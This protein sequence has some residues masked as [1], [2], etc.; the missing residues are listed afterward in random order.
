MIVMN[1]VPFRAVTHI[2]IA[3]STS[4]QSSQSLMY[5]NP[6]PIDIV[7]HDLVYSKITKH[8]QSTFCRPIKYHKHILNG[9]S[10]IIKH[11]KVTAIMGASGAGKTTLLNILAQRVKPTRDFYLSGQVL[12]NMQPYA[13][14][15]FGDFAS[16][17][18]QAD[19]LMETLTVRELLQFAA[20]LKING[21]V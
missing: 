3:S 20:A 17:I 9:V 11:G 14:E 21:T 12:A 6:S 7:F 15:N 13:Y 10:G 16:Y 18:M 2:P 8:E 1:S 19:L 4:I 5:S